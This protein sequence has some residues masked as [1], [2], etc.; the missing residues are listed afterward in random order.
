VS[1]AATQGREI[2]AEL[3]PLLEGGPASWLG[4][5]DAAGNPEATRVRGALVDETRRT[6]TA[7][8]PTAQAGATFDN[9]RINP[10]VAVSFINVSD[11]RAVQIKGEVLSTRP[12]TAQEHKLQT[13]CMRA[14]I[15]AVASIG[16][17]PELMK[18]HVLWPSTA[19]VIRVDEIFVQTPGPGAGRPWP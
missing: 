8:V 14:F 17:Q 18:R 3:V 6:L 9:L 19:V 11:N 10:R 7:F 4:T 2:P 15:D 12:S 1:V 5:C 16:L 13:L